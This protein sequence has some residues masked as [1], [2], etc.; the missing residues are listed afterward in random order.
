MFFWVEVLMSLRQPTNVEGT[1]DPLET[2]ELPN[3]QLSNSFF[4]RT[5]VDKKRETLSQ[6]LWHQPLLFPEKNILQILEEKCSWGKYF[7]AGGHVL[8]G[9]K[10]F[11]VGKL[12]LGGEYWWSRPRS[13]KAKPIE[14]DSTQWK[15]FSIQSN[16]HFDIW[17]SIG[18]VCLDGN[19]RLR[20]LAAIAANLL[21]HLVMI[22]LQEST[23]S[24]ILSL[25]N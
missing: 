22:N 10:W 18:S 4:L 5:I 25:K 13:K 14:E 1:A 3:S 6:Y 17:V 2:P 9:G 8:F 20:D 19:S 21:Q 7:F 24:W 15:S 12:F 11:L 23:R 16:K